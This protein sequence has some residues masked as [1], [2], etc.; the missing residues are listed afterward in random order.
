LTVIPDDRLTHFLERALAIEVV[1]RAL[2]DDAVIDAAQPI[3]FTQLAPNAAVRIFTRRPV[4]ETGPRETQEKLTGIKLGHFAGFYRRSWRA[5]DFM[6]GRLDAA[7]RIV[8]FLV[9][10]DW[11]TRLGAGAT[12]WSGLT[13]ELVP[14]GVEATSQDQRQ[15]VCEA[16]SDAATNVDRLKAFEELDTALAAYLRTAELPTAEQAPAL[17]TIVAQA[18]E[19]DLRSQAPGTRGVLTR[20]LLAR[21]VQYEALRAEL[22]VIVEQTRLDQDLGASTQP[23]DWDTTGSLFPVLSELRDYAGDNSL[24]KR[25]GRDS[26]DEAASI[27][28]LR[29][30]SRTALV[31]LAALPGIA[32]PLARVTTPG[33]LPF[34]AVAGLT[35]RAKLA[36]LAAIAAFCAASF[37]LT[38]RILTADN[39]TTDKH[40][41]TPL[42]E[43]ISWPVLAMGLAMLVLVGTF[44][45]FGW[46]AIKASK[47][48]TNGLWLIAVLLV[49]GVVAI[50]VGL[51]LLGPAQALTGSGGL[52]PENWV[53]GLAF[54][55]AGLGTAGVR[56]LTAVKDLTEAAIVRWSWATSLISFLAALVFLGW[57]TP[58]VVHALNDGSS[59]HASHRIAAATAIASLPVLLFY[60]LPSWSRSPRRSTNGAAARS[61]AE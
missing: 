25:L 13:N 22:P 51:Y 48:V 44:A 14:T 23:F 33:R 6:W 8:D 5:N 53:I 35:A 50:G 60:F 18:L 30:V 32:M 59:W 2:V 55:G 9:D 49:S 31:A 57:S 3:R 29:T 36:N 10:P 24:P 46:R 42:G 39:R 11:E 47:H 19:L 20:I 45:F 27:L 38:A 7:T 17:R 34:L 40:H 58:H 4:T 26:A 41:Q 52:A 37:Y 56:Y 1:R 54:I 61:S 21:A 15:L 12:P 43:I 28:A 16:L